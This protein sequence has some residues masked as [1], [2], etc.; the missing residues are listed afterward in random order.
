AGPFGPAPFAWLIPHATARRLPQ[1]LAPT[2][3]ACADAWN[4]STSL[5]LKRNRPRLPSSSSHTRYAGTRLSPSR[6]Q[7]TIV[8]RGT[9]S[10][11][12]VCSRDIQTT[13]T[14]R[15]SLFFA[16]I[17]LLASTTRGGPRRWLSGTVPT[18]DPPVAGP[19][20]ILRT[21]SPGHRV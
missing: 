18:R 12:A 6:A 17:L 5:F 19:R 11:S 10:A 8:S 13:S 7:P 15:C 9:P 16:M 21:P 3:W 2:S 1:E 14:G 4:D 20:R